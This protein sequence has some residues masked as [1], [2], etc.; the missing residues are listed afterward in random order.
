MEHEGST[1]LCGSAATGEAF[2]FAKERDELVEQDTPNSSFFLFNQSDSEAQFRKY[3]ENVGWPAVSM[4]TSKPQSGERLVVA[5]SPYGDYWELS[6]ATMAEKVGRIAGFDGNLRRLAAIENEI[7]ACGMGRIVLQRRSAGQWRS[8]GPGPL[9]GDPPVVGF[10]G[11]AGFS[12][13]EMYAVGWNGEIWWGDKGRW[14]RIDSPTSSILSAICCSPDGS[15]YAVGHDGTMVKGRRDQWQVVDTGRAEN[16]R[17]VAAFS[18]KVYAVSDF[19]VFTLGAA[20]LEEDTDFADADRP[21]TCL[22][23]LQAPDGLVS[24]G[25]KDVFI[26]RD[27]PWRRLV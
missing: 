18:G 13:A 25:T 5:V 17:D 10:E 22:H 7:F 9:K 4:A 16:L 1:F 24:L 15:A 20:G 8:I 14:R 27:G 19:A 3:D 26:K 6:P 11:L 2:F 23:L 12:T 21:A